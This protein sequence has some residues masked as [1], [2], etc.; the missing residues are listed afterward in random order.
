MSI[1]EKSSTGVKERDAALFRFIQVNT[2]ASY[3]VRHLH[4][5]F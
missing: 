1:F 4:G 5:Y 3:W 2:I